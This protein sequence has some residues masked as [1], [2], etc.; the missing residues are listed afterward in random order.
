MAKGLRLSLRE[1]LVHRKVAFTA[2]RGGAGAIVP[3]ALETDEERDER[4]D[5]VDTSE[6]MESGDDADEVDRAKD[7]RRTADG[8][9][10]NELTRGQ[11][12]RGGR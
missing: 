6:T 10:S 8:Y 12:E 1:L 4:D 3:E 2:K 11:N 5:R 7:D 9:P